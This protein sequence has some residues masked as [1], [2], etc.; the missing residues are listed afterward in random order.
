MLGP[1]QQPE[2]PEHQKESILL[3]GNHPEDL[4]ALESL[5]D[6]M[7]VDLVRA[8]TSE[9]AGRRASM[10]DLALIIL[11]IHAPASEV[12]DV[13]KRL[14]GDQR[15]NHVPLIL[16]IPDEE[17]HGGLSHA[18]DAVGIE[19][20]SRPLNPH[21]VRRRVRLFTDLHRQ[22]RIIDRQLGEIRKL[23]GLLPICA[24]CKRIRNDTGYWEEIEVYV[25]DRAEVEFSHGLCPECMERHYPQLMERMRKALENGSISTPNEA[26]A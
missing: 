21:L 24:G 22:Q 7:N 13:T 2:Q 16:I 12:L 4:F 11:D 5:L 9:E 10:H 26:E 25:R 14:Q 18:C 6:G 3:L 23:R 20:L 17:G 1:E 19:H 15:L 8:G